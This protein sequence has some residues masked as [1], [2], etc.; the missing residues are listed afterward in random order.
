MSCKLIDNMTIDL[1]YKYR[2]SRGLKLYVIIQMGP[3]SVSSHA[4]F[5]LYAGITR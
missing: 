4:C 1:T 5:I 3:A 2:T